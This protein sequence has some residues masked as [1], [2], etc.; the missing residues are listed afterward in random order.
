MKTNKTEARLESLIRSLEYKMAEDGRLLKDQMN[1]ILNSIKPVNI[2]KSTLNEWGSSS[3]L[4][5]K[6]FNA[7]LGMSA[8]YLAKIIF[9]RRS[10]N[11]FRKLLGAAIMMGV[12]S[13]VSRNPELLKRMGALFLGFIRKARAQRGQV[14]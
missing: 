6:L 5:P 12:T 7:A 1:G 9:V 2:L 8:G 13:A 11:P 4:N 10:K 3:E 14:H